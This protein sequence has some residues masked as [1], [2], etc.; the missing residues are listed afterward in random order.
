MRGETT[1]TI[2]ADHPAFPG[3]FPGR[4]IVP[5]VV[6]LDAALHAVEQERQTPGEQPASGPA[7]HCQIASAKFLSPVQ[8]GE[9][10][11]ISYTR[12]DKGPTRFEIACGQRPVASGTFV[13][14]TAP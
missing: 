11:T 14:G 5:G 13:F 7:L 6:L 3:H 10:L 2:A 8:P 12:T 4:P 9:T 1:L